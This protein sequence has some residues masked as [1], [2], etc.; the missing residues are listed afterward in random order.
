MRFKYAGFDKK[1]IILC[2]NPEEM[3][4][5]ILEKSENDIYGILYF[6]SQ[7]TLKEQLKKEGYL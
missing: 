5:T 6:D 4:S 3:L 1:K 7:G 2:P